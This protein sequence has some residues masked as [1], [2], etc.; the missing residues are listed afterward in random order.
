MKTTAGS[1][2]SDYIWLTGDEAGAMLADLAAD[3]TPLHTLLTRL[4]G[5]LS[6][7]R[8]HLLVEQTELRRRATAKFTQADRMFFTRIGLEQATDEW[9]A[10]YK[11]SRFLVQRAGASSP[12]SAIADL[13]CGIGGDLIALAMRG[14]V[15]GVDLDPIAAHFAA[16]NS[17]ASVTVADVRDFDLRSA[18]AWHIDP[19]RRPTGHRTTSLEYCEPDAIAIERL[20][21][22]N[23]NAA[24]KLAP[25]TTVPRHWEGQCELEWISR[26]RECRQLVAW[27][28]DLARSAG[29][30]S[31]TVV[32]KE[33]G[34]PV[35]TITGAANQAV[36][37]VPRPDR[38]VFDVDAA[39]LAAHL[40]GALA[41][42]H[43][44]TALDRGP[45]YLT[46]PSP[47]DDA[48]LAC[49]EVTDVLPFEKRLLARHLQEKSIGR[50]EIKKRGVDFDPD[51]F[52][53]ELKLR[54]DYAATLL[55][56][57][58]AGRPA[59]ILAQRV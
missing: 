57:P 52:R 5:T 16:T 7:E 43:D 54:G 45:T 24:M 22:R 3:A 6:A 4:R 29:R 20:L 46:G 32:P 56:T 33:H 59:A 37:I 40:K 55:V 51:A 23:A 36:T 14:N 26:D 9:I 35:R 13:C 47:I 17:G 53:R 1:D 25:A 27:H 18:A 41:A 15:V 31:A 42:E 44:L 48:A 11:A 12:P 2:V 34:L 8:A 19:D 50:L 49:F 58:I 38:Y 10:A 30:R 21:Q 28:G 39:V